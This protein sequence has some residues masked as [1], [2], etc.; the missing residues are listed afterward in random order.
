VR[1]VTPHR[2]HYIEVIDMDDACG[3]DNKGHP[4]YVGS[5]SEVNYIKYLPSNCA[6]RASRVG[7]MAC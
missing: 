3:R 5:L 4:R 7:G 6:R 1:Q 2:F